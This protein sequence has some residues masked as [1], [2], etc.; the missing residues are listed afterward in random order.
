M[1]MSYLGILFCILFFSLSSISAQDFSLKSHDPPFPCPYETALYFQPNVFPR[2]NSTDK[3]IVLVN[4]SGETVQLLDTLSEDNVRVINW[5]PD[6]RYLSGAIGTS[7][8]FFPERE[9][10]DGEDYV[11]WNGRQVIIWD[12]VNGSRIQSFV[13]PG[14]YLNQT[15]VAWSPDSQNALILGGCGSVQ[16]S[17]THER[18]RYDWLWN[19]ATNNRVRIGQLP[20][21]G[22]WNFS[23]AWFN[24]F[25]W[26]E[27]HGWLWGSGIGGAV[28]YDVDTGAETEV[29]ASC[30]NRNCWPEAR[31]VFSNDGTKLV[32]YSI[33]QPGS[34][35]HIGLTIYDLTSRLSTEINVEGLGAPYIPYAE[36]HPAALS[37]DNR[38]LVVGYD[39]LRVWDTQNLPTAIEDRL[40]IYRHGGPEALI[41]SVHFSDWG[42]IETSS[43]EGIQHW[44]L[45]TGA[46]LP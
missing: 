7:R 38:Y 2:F 23:R 33:A 22:Q 8:A 43:S 45:H 46:F 26:D 19:Q 11:S 21:D 41:D 10:L 9:S 20:E 12:T 25:Y 31:F 24:Q 16:F 27:S 36:Y 1:R 42:V 30:L 39:A 6:C 18:A 34:D 32:V 14:R 37:D 17:C 15:T 35:G 3:T 44:D 13:N 5:S 40:P 29:F 4:E 28:T